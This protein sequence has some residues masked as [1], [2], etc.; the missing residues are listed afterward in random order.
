MTNVLIAFNH[1]L[2]IERLREQGISN[3]D[4][5]DLLNE[6]SPEEFKKYGDGLPDWETFISFYNTNPEKIESAIQ[7]GYKITFLTKGTLKTM[8]KIKF[9]VIENND[10]QDNGTTLDGFTISYPTFEELKEMLSMNWIIKVKSEH[11]NE[12]AFSI[13][14]NSGATSI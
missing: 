8:L 5:I 11:E 9:G 10:Y 2:M 13:D 6:G 4:I 14:L 3:G 12:V 1:A 7:L